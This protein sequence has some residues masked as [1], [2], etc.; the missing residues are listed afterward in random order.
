MFK[1]T[2]SIQ[3]E[4]AMKKIFEFVRREDGATA[5]EYSIMA[6]AIA[7]VIVAVVTVIGGKTNNSFVDLNSKW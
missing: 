7:A 3:S 4:S 1:T 6:A 5:V 2:T